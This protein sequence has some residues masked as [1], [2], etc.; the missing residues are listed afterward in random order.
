MGAEELA[1][2][3]RPDAC[4]E[5][6]F[7]PPSSS[8][9]GGA[10]TMPEPVRMTPA[11]LLRLHIE[12]AVRLGEIRVEAMRAEAAW[13]QHLDDWHEEGRAAVQSRDADVALLVRVLEG[14]RGLGRLHATP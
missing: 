8:G 6:T 1:D 10:A 2:D 9:R 12:S 4:V 13:R 11:E 7:V 3:P 14:L 5:L